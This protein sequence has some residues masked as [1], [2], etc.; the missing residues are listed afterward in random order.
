M[1]KGLNRGNIISSKWW[2]GWWRRPG[3][4]MDQYV[5][6]W[7]EWIEG[8]GK[9]KNGRNAI[10]KTYLASDWLVALEVCGRL[11]GRLVGW[12]LYGLF[13][14]M[15]VRAIKKILVPFSKSCFELNWFVLFLFLFLF[16]EFNFFFKR[17]NKKRKSKLCHYFFSRLLS[18]QR[19]KKD[20]LYYIIFFIAM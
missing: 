16:F 9:C 11:F 19:P 3:V 2:W 7:G 12:W 6:G 8:R 17:Q 4:V 5:G 18:L 1:T 20:S 13:D 15:M 14:R 10:W